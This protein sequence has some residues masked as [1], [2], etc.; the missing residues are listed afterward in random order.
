MVIVLLFSS[1]VTLLYLFKS[2]FLSKY[3]TVEIV[4]YRSGLIYTIQLCRMQHAYAMLTIAYVADATYR[5]GCNAGYAHDSLI[6]G[7]LPTGYANLAKSVSRCKGR[8]TNLLTTRLVS[9]ASL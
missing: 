4:A 5:R 6:S 7:R 2:S 9:Q 8:F 1:V 3:H